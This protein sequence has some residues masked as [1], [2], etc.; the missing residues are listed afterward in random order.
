MKFIIVCFSC[1]HLARS[2]DNA[3]DGGR[4][5]I[6]SGI[7]ICFTNTP[8]YVV[9]V[10]CLSLVSPR[11]R[12]DAFTHVFLTFFYM[13]LYFCCDSNGL[14]LHCDTFECGTWD[15]IYFPAVPHVRSYHCHLSHHLRHHCCHSLRDRTGLFFP[16]TFSRIRHA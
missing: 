14:I 16:D 3:A 12:R 9:C 8:T 10:F 7:T 13:I 6:C 4:A 1:T 11:R 2:H 5:G 15:F